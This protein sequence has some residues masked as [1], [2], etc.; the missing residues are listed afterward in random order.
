MQISKIINWGVPLLLSL[1]AI[2]LLIFYPSPDNINVKDKPTKKTA[3]EIFDSRTLSEK[4]TTQFFNGSTTSRQQQIEALTNSL[5]YINQ[6]ETKTSKLVL[7]K[8][9]SLI[10]I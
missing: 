2:G 9:L 7:D 3:T 10:H 6:F 8:L 1:T 4:L 5:N